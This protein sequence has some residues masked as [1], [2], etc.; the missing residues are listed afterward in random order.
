VHEAIQPDAEVC[1]ELGHELLGAEL[2]SR[3]DGR[4]DERNPGREE[5]DERLRSRVWITVSEVP[6]LRLE[7]HAHSLVRVLIKTEQ[8][9][10]SLVWEVVV[11]AA[12]AEE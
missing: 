7:F 6:V 10:R 11:Q 8:D 5:G 12:K 2:E 1:L 9:Q 4:P 3:P